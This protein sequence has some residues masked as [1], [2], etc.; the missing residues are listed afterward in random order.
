MSPSPSRPYKLLVYDKGSFFISHRD[1]EKAP[2]M[3]ATLVEAMPPQSEG[4]DLIVRHRNREARLDLSCDEPSEFAFAA[5]YA[6]CVHEVLPV[7]RG[8]RAALVFNLVVRMGKGAPPQP[9]NYEA[10]TAQVADL[11]SAWAN[12]KARRH[13]ESD[14]IGGAED[15]EGSLQ[16]LVYPLEHVYTPAEPAFDKLKGADAAVARLL[17]A[18][19]PRAG[20]DRHLAVL[21]VWESGSAQYNGSYRRRYRRSWHE[22]VNDEDGD[23]HSEC[24]VV[25]VLNGG[26][27]LSEWRRPDGEPTTLAK[28]PIADCEI[29]PPDALDDMEP[30][31]EHF[32]EATGMVLWP[33]TR[34]LV[35]LNQAGL[36]A[37]LPY[38]DELIKK[39][40][41]DSVS[42]MSP[43]R[44][45]AHVLAGHMLA[46]WRDQVWCARD[47]SEP[48]N[49]ARCSAYSLA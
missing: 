12:A 38:L 4:G 37:T 32:R 11:L 31:E 33:T 27:P 7:T 3:F 30:D 40:N 49:M 28:L 22:Q 17:S 42:K 48:S 29:S 6:D 19:A 47:R 46:T 34:V 5:F 14:D 21:K 26:K 8:Y 43:L 41:T 36:A 39:W 24:E 1:T 18:A 25:E 45:Q 15:I 44:L 35:V 16:K 10:E 23:D 2:G 9:P 13:R 20:C